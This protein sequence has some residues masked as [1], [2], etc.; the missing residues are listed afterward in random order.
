MN[1]GHLTLAYS[2]AK[3]NNQPSTPIIGSAAWD[4]L[5]LFCQPETVYFAAPDTYPSAMLIDL[6][7]SSHVTQLIDLR[8]IPHFSFGGTSRVQFFEALADLKIEYFRISGD[9]DGKDSIK[10]RSREIIES[11]LNF[12]PSMVFS[13]INPDQ[14][15]DIAIVVSELRKAGVKFTPVFTST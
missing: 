13:D 12:G 2:E 5:D 15:S 1:R 6:L 4:Q 9:T 11:R 14:D 3:G 10:S 7:S 8:Q